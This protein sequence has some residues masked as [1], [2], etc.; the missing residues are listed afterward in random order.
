MQARRA[1]SA[2]AARF[3]PASYGPGAPF[4]GNALRFDA[5]AGGP[6][7]ESWFLK[8]V[9]P[10]GRR[11]LWVK[12]TIL[13]RADGSPPV[14][15]AWAIAFDR[16]AVHRGVKQTQ[17]FSSARFAPAG[18][19]LHVCDVR[20]R[21]GAL[22]GQVASGEGS[23]A[24]DLAFTTDAPA[25]VPLP[26]RA[27][28]EGRLPSSKLV[29]PH[30]DARFSGSY[31]AFGERV[32]V[33]GWRGMQGHNW[34]RGHAPSYAW[35]HVNQW[36]EPHDLVLEGVTARVPVGPWLAPPLTLMV[37]VHR[38]VRYAFDA[39]RALLG[40][41]GTIGRRSFRF[42]AESRIAT[43]EGELA[44]DDRDFV[45]LR[46]D[47]PQ[48]PPTW[49]LNSKIASGQVRFEVRGREAVLLRTRA[50][51]LEIGTLD[52]RHGVRVVCV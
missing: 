25:L 16:D 28:Y 44:A 10:M 29:S 8:L 40:A 7:V 48:G 27:M 42:S 33:E 11:A 19:D 20:L 24:F 5:A 15:E 4:D 14:A 43:I 18:L 9:D 22:S 35:A 36:D 51:A 39:P 12:A 46:Y 41:R 45:A 17:P 3:A 47:N 31:E 21:D 50:A 49:C 32:A 1:L 6:H 30:P 13:S 34:G 2:L 52:E 37:V 38:G 26:L 23:V